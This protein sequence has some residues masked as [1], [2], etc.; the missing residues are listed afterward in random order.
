VT[1]DTDAPLAGF[2]IAVTADRRREELTRLLERRGARVV[3]TPA[4][5]IVVLHDDDE[6]L[7]ATRACISAPLDVVVATTG[8]GFRGWLE[9]AHGWGLAEDLHAR[10][11][12]ARIVARGPKARGAVRAADLVDEWS[13][14]SESSAEVLEYVLAMPLSGRRVAVQ[15]HGEPQAAFCGALRAA[16]AEVIDVPVYRWVLADDVAALRRLITMVVDHQ[17]DAITFTSAPAVVS[18]LRYA[19]SLG[20]GEAF[21]EALR[22]DVLPVCVGPVCSA[23][24]DE[25]GIT[26]VVPERAR[27]GALVRATADEVPARCARRLDLAGRPLELRGHAVCFDGQ[28]VPLP[29][30]PMAVMRALAAEPGRVVSRRD[31]VA[32]L[33]GDGDEHAVEMTVARLRS[34]LGHS[35][36][37]E[38]VVKRG[39]RLA[40]ASI[41]A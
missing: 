36:A 40:V 6:L 37:V 13:P 11:D 2:T 3:G 29:P 34:A 30:G 20:V 1:A 25:L 9:A 32:V 4:I 28:L 24:L 10:L 38:T 39:Y 18:M 33:P 16:G 27:L 15:L 41:P 26:C 14:N 35:A 19:A 17:L 31:L 7:A 5:R 21:V 8:I 23:P 22:H 12:A